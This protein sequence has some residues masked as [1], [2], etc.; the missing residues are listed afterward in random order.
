MSAFRNF[1][2][3][4]R[5][6]GEED[7]YKI[8]FSFAARHDLARGFTGGNNMVTRVF[9]IIDSTYGFSGKVYKSSPEDESELD[10]WQTVFK[11]TS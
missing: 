11:V 7:H 3:A 2:G 9:D 6:Y 1:Y 8:V 4:Q 10:S 5:R